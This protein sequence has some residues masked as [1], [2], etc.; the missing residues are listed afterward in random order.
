[1]PIGTNTTRQPGSASGISSMGGSATRSTS[2]IALACPTRLAH[3]PLPSAPATPPRPATVSSVPVAAGESFKS[4]VRNRIPTAVK[5][6][7]QKLA[8]PVHVVMARSVVLP[9]TKRSPSPISGRSPAFFRRR[10]SGSTVLMRARK[11]ADVR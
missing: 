9:N 3:Q 10:G 6:E 4:L 7:M 11:K 5:A 1:M 2:Q 8:I